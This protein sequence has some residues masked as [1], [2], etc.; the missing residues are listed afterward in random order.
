MQQQR[1]FSSSYLYIDYCFGENKGGEI[2]ML[3]EHHCRNINVK[4]DHI[5]GEQAWFTLEML[6]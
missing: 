2:F 3:L 6:F 5:A 1:E 4:P